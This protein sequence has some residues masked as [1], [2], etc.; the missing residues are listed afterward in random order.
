M[1]KEYD[2]CFSY[3]F[4][5]RMRGFSQHG[6]LPASLT[7]TEKGLQACFDVDRILPT[8]HFKHNATLLA[9]LRTI[10]EDI[11]EEFG[12][13]AK[14]TFTLTIAQYNL[15]V[16]KMYSLFFQAAKTVFFY[17]LRLG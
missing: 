4:L 15:S 10:H 11:H 3:R 12:D 17:H 1:S 2:N 6:H 9:E 14:I 8:P 7:E 13:S 5:T 16:I